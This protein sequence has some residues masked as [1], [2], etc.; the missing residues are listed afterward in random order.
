MSD[1]VTNIQIE[2]VLSSIRRLV[3]EEIGQQPANAPV[4]LAKKPEEDAKLV[5]SPA[6]KVREEAAAQG[7]D[8]WD[9]TEE[10]APQEAAPVWWHRDMSEMTSFE[11]SEAMQ[12]EQPIVEAAPNAPA[13]DQE[14]A[15]TEASASAEIAKAP[16]EGAFAGLEAA[17]DIHDDEWESP[18]GA[19]D[20]DAGV[21]MDA[22]PWQ[23]DEEVEEYV[24]TGDVDTPDAGP[25]PLEA[26]LAD[27]APIASND[28]DALPAD[29]PAAEDVPFTFRPGEKL[30]ERLS[31]KKMS[32][33]HLPEVE[34]F[35]AAEAQPEPEPEVDP[36]AAEPEV[37]LHFDA[38]DAVSYGDDIESDDPMAGAEMSNIFDEDMLRDMVKDIIRQELQG[39]LGERI[40]RNVRKLVRREIQRAISDLSG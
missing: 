34:M 29:D 20:L 40:T 4:K 3:S 8:L 19:E 6:Q 23:G 14:D 37:A 24:A 33:S 32:A 26:V 17:K 5:L 21:A 27:E 30:F 18:E 28:A 13:L 11:S 1:P 31:S 35:E 22:M 12:L 16:L 39:V 9:E 38:D 25:D 2:D 15:N 10:M 7:R 36:V